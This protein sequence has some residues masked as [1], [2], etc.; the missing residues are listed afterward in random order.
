MKKQ[1]FLGLFAFILLAS[2]CAEKK[3]TNIQIKS[4]NKNAKPSFTY[5]VTPELTFNKQNAIVDN[6]SIPFESISAL[7]L[8][9]KLKT[10]WNLGNTLDATNATDLSSEVSWG[11]PYTTQEMIAGLKKS[12]IKTIR[13]PVSWHNHLIDSAYTI[14]PKWMERVKTVVDWAIKN[15]M[16]V[17][18]DSHHD[19]YLQTGIMPRGSG[20]YPNSQNASESA[21]FIYNIWS[22]IC[23]AFN[24]GYDSHLIFE[25]MNEP[26]LAGTMYEWNSDNYSEICIDGFKTLNTLNQLAVDTIRKSGGNNAKRIIIVPSL[27]ASVNS[28]LSPYFKIPDDKTENVDYKKIIISVHMYTPYSF[29]MQ[30][31]GETV[32]TDKHEQEI[33][34]NFQKLDNAFIQKG[35]GVII[36]EYGATNK[37]NDKER[38]RWFSYYLSEATK[39]NIPAIL[40]DNGQADPN[41]MEGERYGFYNRKKNAWYSK[42]ILDA[43]NRNTK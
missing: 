7:D 38:I 24:N 25:T 16:Y 13:I 26:R 5:S 41:Q 9:K 11:M 20:Y 39:Y 19:N 8:T 21:E 35:Y 33:S 2:S 40:W 12:G 1:F 42:E 27:Q 43:I 23:L 3:G 36:G 34:S 37:N 4:Q 14:D 30:T 6:N 22:Q 17:I 10:G 32:F 28:S 15:E 29:A 18:I 31:P